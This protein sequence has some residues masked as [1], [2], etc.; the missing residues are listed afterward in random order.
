[1]G[2][3]TI[4]DDGPSITLSGA[5]APTLDVDESYL[6]NGSTPNAALTSAS[7]AFAGMFTVVQG[8]DGATTSYGVSVSSQGVT[9]NLIDSATGQA[10]VL[11]QSGGT[12]SGYV[13]G[14][15]G[16]AAY[17]VFTLAVDT[18]SG[19]ATLSEFRAVHQNTADNPTDTSEG[20]SLTSGLVTLTATVTDHDG[21]H[22]SQSI[23]LGSKATFHDDGPSLGSFTSGTIPNEVGSLAGFFSLV[24][25]ADGIDH[26]NITGPAITGITYSQSHTADGTTVLHATAGATDVFDLTVR[27]DGTYEFDLVTPQAAT[28]VS[29][30]L[31]GITAGG[32]QNHVEVAG[33][34]V[35]LEALSG[36][37]INA[38]TQGFGVAN[39]HF[40]TGESFW[41]E[42]HSP[43]NTATND[44]HGVNGQLVD[45]VTFTA[46]GS[47]TVDWTAYNYAADGTTIL[48]QQS[49]TATVVGGQ[50]IIDPTIQFNSMTVASTSGDMRLDNLSYSKTV[51]PPDLNLAFQVSATDH[52]GD[53]TSTS[54]LNIH[55]VASGSGGSFTLT[56]TAGDDVIAGSSH[57]DTIAGGAGTDIA[58]YTGS[59]GAISIHLADD[60][61]ASGAPAD[62]NNPAA[63]TI[64]GGD[65]A[66]D[67]L[68]GIEGLIGGS[69][70]DHLFG[71][72]LAN[73]LAGGA[74]NDTLNGGG[75][76]DILI[77]GAGQDTLIGGTG[78]DT[79]KLDHLDIKDLISDYSGVGGDGDKIDLTALFDTAP[80]G[81][82]SNYVHY[83]SGTG[84]LSVDTSGSGNPANFVDVAQLTNTPVAGTITILY[85]DNTHAQHTATI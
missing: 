65:A 62:P 38:S 37:G 59:V 46:N 60:G 36:G 4:H 54:S 72:A 47:G 73:Y 28:A 41:I 63:G 19:Q 75:G 44:A 68:T 9:S 39:N 48:N 43:G 67:T 10:V 15:S 79:F 82:I 34:T 58:D 64:G 71:N 57:T 25:G 24:Q 55:Q 7:A 33:G 52:D 85:D 49:G 11:T 1:G 81:N 6:A 2:Q 31:G 14:H 76:N 83:N 13:T 56:G 26:F 32:P 61:H 29:V 70:D 21:D 74:G 66:G 40:T 27:A 8:A 17:L 20:I 22:A 45:S 16:D 5:A 69:G 50:L 30:A 42:F 12:V 18:A 23:D 77:G 78:A 35:E 3:I 80:A 51:L 84:A 53:T